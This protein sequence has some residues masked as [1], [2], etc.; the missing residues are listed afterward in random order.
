MA[1]NGETLTIPMTQTF[2]AR[3]AYK[4][5]KRQL[6]AHIIATKSEPG[7]RCYKLV[8]S[9]EDHVHL[10]IANASNTK[11]TDYVITEPIG[12]VRRISIKTFETL[13]KLTLIGA[14]FVEE[15]TPVFGGV[16]SYEF[17]D[18]TFAEGVSV[19][20]KSR[21]GEATVTYTDASILPQTALIKCI[22]GIDLSGTNG[23]LGGLLSAL[24]RGSNSS[25][26]S[27]GETSLGALA[28]ALALARSRSGNNCP[29]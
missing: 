26:S 18:C 25:S 6:L 21:S 12:V 22:G 10:W 9:Y 27:D 16:T 15:D 3:Y 4:A 1:T 2:T 19:H 8:E 24:G 11:P 28:L 13:G 5:A 20:C 29:C 17:R 23:G 7:I 14:N